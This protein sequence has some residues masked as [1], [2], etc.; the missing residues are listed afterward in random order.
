M[1]FEDLKA[2]GFDGEIAE[3]IIQY[4]FKVNI[5][6]LD[7]ELDAHGMKLEVNPKSPNYFLLNQLLML[8]AKSHQTI[9]KA[10]ER[11]KN[12]IKRNQAQSCQ[13]PKLRTTLY[14]QFPY[15]Y[16]CGDL[17]TTKNRTIDHYIPR[18]KGGPSS[19]DNYVTCCFECNNQKGDLLPQEFEEIIK[20]RELV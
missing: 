12:R 19:V 13:T 6:D 4:G 18:S 3:K 2:I 16:Y 5:K 14:K 20:N 7:V 10:K 17:L 9:K 1:L 11:R 8:R 15:C